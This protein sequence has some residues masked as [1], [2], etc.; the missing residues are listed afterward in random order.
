MIDSV[1]MISSKFRLM[2]GVIWYNVDNSASFGFITRIK[3]A[4]SEMPS[5]TSGTPVWNGETPPVMT[6]PLLGLM[7][8]SI[9]DFCDGSLAGV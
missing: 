7:M 4:V 1:D 2:D 6:R 8:C 9:K 5:V 3:P